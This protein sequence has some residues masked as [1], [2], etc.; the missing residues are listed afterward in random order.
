[1]NR[2]VETLFLVTIL[3][4]CASP[5]N[6]YEEVEKKRFEELVESSQKRELQCE[7]DNNKVYK[8]TFKERPS[9]KEQK[10]LV[11]F[12][13]EFKFFSSTES[14]LIKYLN[15]HNPTDWNFLNKDELNKIK[16]CDK[17]VYLSVASSVIEKSANSFWTKTNKRAALKALSQLLKSQDKLKISPLD[18]RLISYV[19]DYFLENDLIRASDA[20][21]AA[22]T[23]VSAKSKIYWAQIVVEPKGEFSFYKRRIDY[24]VSESLFNQMNTLLKRTKFQL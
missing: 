10:L 13:E 20:T 8:I 6:K 14:D 4:A 11:K 17:I 7:E 3:G 12:L 5:K 9:H 18:M 22:L 21:Y 15:S 24:S 1:M 23:N 16:F 2:I 19:L